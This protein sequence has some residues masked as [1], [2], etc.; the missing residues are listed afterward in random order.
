MTIRHYV[1]TVH[2]L[3]E[4]DDSVTGMGN[5]QASACDAISEHLRNCEPEI[6]DWGY[7]RT[8]VPVPDPTAHPQADAKYAA[9]VEV[10]IAIDGDYNEGVFYAFLPESHRIT[11][12]EG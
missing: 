10:E 8:V 5:C 4:L 11:G 2:L 7:A 12:A 6:K 3:I 9:P 1:A